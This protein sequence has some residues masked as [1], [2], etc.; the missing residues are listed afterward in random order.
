MTPGIIRIRQVKTVQACIFLH[1]FVY[2]YPLRSLIELTVMV[3]VA[4]NDVKQV[5]PH[6]FLEGAHMVITG[7]KVRL[8]PLGS[9]IANVSL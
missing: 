7:E 6:V 1:L 4:Q 9:E 2:Q 3:I 5:F 8:A